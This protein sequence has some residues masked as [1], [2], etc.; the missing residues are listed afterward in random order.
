ML[1]GSKRFFLFSG[2]S[3]RGVEGVLTEAIAMFSV[4]RL[5]LRGMSSPPTRAIVILAAKRVKS[6]YLAVISDF[7]L[8]E[9]YL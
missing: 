6:E 2:I 9:F 4:R 5:L 3:G 7:L 1:R 8:V